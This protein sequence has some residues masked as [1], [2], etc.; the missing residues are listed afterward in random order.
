[1]GLFERFLSPPPFV[2]R[3]MED[4]H[5]TDCND[6]YGLFGV[7]DGHAGATCSAQCSRLLRQRIAKVQCCARALPYRP[8]F[9]LP[10][11]TKGPYAWVG[12]TK[13][14]VLHFFLPLVP[15]MWKALCSHPPW[16]VEADYLV[17]FRSGFEGKEWTRPIESVLD[18]MGLN[19]TG[20]EDRGGCGLRSDRRF[21]F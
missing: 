12:G 11:I 16:G 15:E 2:C 8:D 9:P 14:M 19:V 10:T 18:T 7:L 4:S 3:D 17:F 5:I 21:F 20:P 13:Q 1:M 6:S